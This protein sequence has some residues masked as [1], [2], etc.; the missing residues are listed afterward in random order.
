MS[1]IGCYLRA[2]IQNKQ[3]PMGDVTRISVQ[4]RYQYGFYTSLEQGKNM[5]HCVYFGK[6]IFN[7]FL[8]QDDMYSVRFTFPVLK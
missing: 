1:L 4:L 2:K 5:A 7:A 6:K 8:K 3:Q